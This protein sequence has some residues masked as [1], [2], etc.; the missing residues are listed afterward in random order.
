[1]LMLNCEKNFVSK[2]V[3]AWLYTMWDISH[4]FSWSVAKSGYSILCDH[5]LT[6]LKACVRFL[7]TQFCAGEHWCNWILHIIFT[8]LALYDD[9]QHCIMIRNTKL[10]LALSSSWHLMK[11]CVNQQGHILISS[12]ISMHLWLVLLPF[13]HN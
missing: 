4:L 2:V 12:L 13:S 6:R 3:H 8:I 11:H 10:S 9:G 7:H 1:M 5:Y